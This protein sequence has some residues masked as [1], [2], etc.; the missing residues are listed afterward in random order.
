MFTVKFYSDDGYRQLI[1][2]A[3]SLTILKGEG[4]EAE[5]TLHQRNQSEDSRID[6]KHDVLR[7]PS[8]PQVFAKAIIENAAGRTTQIIALGPWPNQASAEKGTTQHG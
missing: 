8:W 6:I 2:S 3:E 4:D 5:I 1:R 7:D